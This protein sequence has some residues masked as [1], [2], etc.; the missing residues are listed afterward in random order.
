MCLGILSVLV[1]ATCE[2][3]L[4]CFKGVLYLHV[5]CTTTKSWFAI[6]SL[7]VKHFLVLVLQNML[8]FILEEP[9]QLPCVHHVENYSF[10]LNFWFYRIEICL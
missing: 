1:D 4:L 10:N 3:T 5:L 7:M 8:S 9:F 6:A 2:S